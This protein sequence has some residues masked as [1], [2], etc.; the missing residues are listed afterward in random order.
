MKIR[1]LASSV[2]W[3][4]L[5]F[6]ANRSSVFA[7]PANV[8]L[9]SVSWANWP[10]LQSFAI[11]EWQGEWLV[12]GGRTDGLHQRQ[13]WAAFS[14]A[15]QPQTLWVL[16]PQ[17]GGMW[18]VPTDSLPMEVRDQF[19]STNLQAATLGD[20]MYLTG[21][22]G[23]SSSSGTHVTHPRIT[24]I[25]LS[26]AISSVKNGGIGLHSCIQSKTDSRFAVT[27]GK[28]MAWDETLVL[29]G[30]HRF[31][32]AYNPMGHATYTQ[33]YASKA[34]Q[35]T[36][37]DSS[38]SF[39][40]GN[41]TEISDTLRLH[42]RDWNVLPFRSDTLAYLLGFSGV[43]QRGVDLP[44]TSGVAWNG[45]SVWTPSGFS[46]RLNQYHC[47]SL[48][49][50]D[51]L[52]QAYAA[53][54]FGGIAQYLPTPGGGLSAD[55][56]VPFVKTI[57]LVSHQNGMWSERP[58]STALPQFLGASSEF[59]LAPGVPRD[60][61]GLIR[62]AELTGDSVF[63]GYIYGGIVSG[64]PLVFFGNSSG[65]SQSTAQL[66]KVYWI[67]GALHVAEGSLRPHLIDWA[68][69]REKGRGEVRVLP[70]GTAP[71]ELRVFDRTGRLLYTASKNRHDGTSF[72]W[73]FPVRGA[74]TVVIQ[75]RDLS[76]SAEILSLE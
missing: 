3:I 44:Y 33:T 41:Y 35:W 31:D 48:G 17:T 9:E 29:L 58:L 21:G 56:N 54:F 2:G 27:G 47:A 57:G 30:G 45:D 40:I 67:R 19:K 6:L 37:S 64:A 74:A 39:R 63:I 23:L 62:L 53:V 28:L 1:H 15:G 11:G 16:N 50:Y 20:W 46:Q 13:P 68:T 51:S 32:G 71:L 72:T 34:A 4:V 8:S 22:Y 75:Q 26:Q 70:H 73:E 25:H 18:S 24:R 69:S 61:Y 10:A 42:R 12:V 66:F 59:L 43:F 7:Q 55:P 36:P 52:T 38:N 49:L 76:A 65:S 14:S 5:A 60:A